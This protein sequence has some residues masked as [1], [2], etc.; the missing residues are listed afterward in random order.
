MSGKKSAATLL[1]EIAEERYTFGCISD[2]RGGC[3][4]RPPD[5]LVAVHTYASPKNNPELKRPLA[6]IHPDL[7]EV[8]STR[9]G[10]TPGSSALADAITVLEGKAQRTAPIEGDGDALAALLGGGKDSTATR[11]VQMA[12]QRFRFG[13]T[14]TGEPYAVPV[15]G[16]NVAR[17]LRGGRRSLRAWQGSTTRK[18]RVPPTVRH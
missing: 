2:S 16:P 13:V 9:H 5:D 18:P 4:V 10:A 3:G 6:D 15:D 1:V 14:L 7:A 17:M 8:Y 11:L 12:Q